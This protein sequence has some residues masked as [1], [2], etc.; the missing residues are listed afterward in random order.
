M[1][2]LVVYRKGKYAVEALHAGA[3]PFYV[4][5]QHHLGVGMGIK[6]KILTELAAELR[7][8][9]KLPVVY[10]S[11]PAK[12]HWLTSAVDVDDRQTGVDKGS[13]TAHEHSALVGT[14]PQQSSLHILIYLHVLPHILHKADS[15]CNS[16]HKYLHR[17]T[18]YGTL[19]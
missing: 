8:V 10:D 4:A 12:A 11:I 15:S 3:A 16:A 2:L 5:F 6:V 7:C 9:V 18:A 19:R 14:A 1:L 13:L 17:F